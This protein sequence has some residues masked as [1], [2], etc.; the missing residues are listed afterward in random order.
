M[1]SKYIFC[2]YGTIQTAGLC[3]S[4]KREADMSDII[5]EISRI[6]EDEA[7]NADSAY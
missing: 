7:A 4:Q 2:S 5:S 1:Q 6:S 3:S